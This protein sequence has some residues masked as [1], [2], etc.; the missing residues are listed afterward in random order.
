M[1]TSSASEKCRPNLHPYL[2]EN[3]VP[4]RALHE[5]KSIDPL[6]AE[7]DSR[8]DG[9]GRMSFDGTSREPPPPLRR[10]MRD[11]NEAKS[12]SFGVVDVA[13]HWSPLRISWAGR[14]R[15]ARAC[16]V[17]FHREISACPSG[18]S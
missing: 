14:Q 7:R 15:E 8:R 18:P 2:E 11:Q 1:A 9:V 3:V 10:M 5:M 4:V 16:L 13:P 12:A 17:H 6:D